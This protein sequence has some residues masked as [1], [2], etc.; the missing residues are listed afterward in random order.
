MVYLLGRSVSSLSIVFIFDAHIF[1][2]SMSQLGASSRDLIIPPA[3]PNNT[4]PDYPRE[5]DDAYILADRILPQPEGTVSKLTG[6]VKCVQVYQTMDDLVRIELAHG[7][8]VYAWD[9][10]KHY[11]HNALLEVKKI[12]ESLPFELRVDM[13]SASLKADVSAYEYVPPAYPNNQPNHDVR[14]LFAQDE[15]KKRSV[16]YEIQKANIYAS[17]LAT[18]SHYVEQYSSLRD[19]HL[20][21]QRAKAQADASGSIVYRTAADF[22]SSSLAAAA[23]QAAAEQAHDDT[24][25]MFLAEREAVVLD[26]FSVLMSIDQANM[27]PNGGSLISKIRQVACTLLNDRA[28]RKGEHE[29][30]SEGYLKAFLEI[31]TR[32]EKTGTGSAPAPVPVGESAGTMTAEDEEQELR[33]WADLRE[34]QQKMARTGLLTVG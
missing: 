34:Q 25:N 33:N 30:R 14:H 1:T 18:R 4:Y 24:D 13:K 8:A 7:I 11:L 21:H 3:T 9:Q 28:D 23:V 2:R 31:L 26:F 19:I 5:V 27:E 16:Q 12:S 6:F 17:L 32:L 15:S 10:Q 20:T 22:S 29:L